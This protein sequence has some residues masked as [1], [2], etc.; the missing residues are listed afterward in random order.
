M[1][2]AIFTFNPFAENTYV[3]F[4]DSKE[5]V[6]IDPGCNTKEEE[7]ELSNFIESKDLKPVL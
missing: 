5:C 2:V 4:D 7:E 1:E 3:L 6:I